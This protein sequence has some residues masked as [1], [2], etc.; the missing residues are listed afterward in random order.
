MTV[1]EQLERRTGIVGDLADSVVAHDNQLDLLIKIADKHET[2]IQ[3]LER[4]L[5][6]YLNTLPRR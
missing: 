5:Q 4:Q 2:A 3:N 6:A 1:E